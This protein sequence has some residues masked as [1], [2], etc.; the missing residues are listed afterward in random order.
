MI[1][2]HKSHTPSLAPNVFI[3]PTAVV[4]GNVEIGE[5]A[6]VWYGAVL[7]G[8]HG[9]IVIGR[10]SN[11][12]DNATIHAPEGGETIIEEDVTI[13]HG[14]VLEG[15]LVRRGAVI[16]MNAVV[17]HC[18]TIGEGCMVAA[19]S[20]VGEGLVAPPHT[21]V[22]GVPAKVKKKLDGSSAEWVGRGAATYRELAREYLEELKVSHSS[23]QNSDGSE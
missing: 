15:C 13:G 17:L 1:F 6:S 5:G 9:R 3:A 2:H 22:A 23:D 16:G 19:G 12:Q 14:A 20:V 4:I 11:V 7:R 8:D 21:L 18:A 10:G